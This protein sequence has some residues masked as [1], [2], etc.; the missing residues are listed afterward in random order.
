MDALALALEGGVQRLGLFHLNQ[1]RTDRQVDAIVSKCR[2][3]VDLRGKAL[4]CF[5]VGTDM[6]FS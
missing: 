2:E 6:E 4:E 1:D 3:I 5:A